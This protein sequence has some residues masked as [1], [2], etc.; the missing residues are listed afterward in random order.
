MATQMGWKE[1]AFWTALA[2][3]IL[4]ALIFLSARESR[5]DGLTDATAQTMPRV[6]QFLPAMIERIAAG[7]EKPQEQIEAIV[8]LSREIARRGDNM[9]GGPI[10]QWIMEPGDDTAS[11]ASKTIMRRALRA[12]VRA[13]LESQQNDYAAR[14][15]SLASRRAALAE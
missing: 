8:F 3:A 15:E 6:E 2:A 1:K 7:R 11:T 4:G 10:A 13:E 14:A 12:S 9:A 5:G